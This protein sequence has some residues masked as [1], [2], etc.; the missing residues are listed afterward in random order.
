M[1]KVFKLSVPIDQK[2]VVKILKILDREDDG[3]SF[4]QIAKKVG[5]N[6]NKAGC[7]DEWNKLRGHLLYMQ[8]EELI[9]ERHFKDKT[10][11]YCLEN[12]GIKFVR[13]LEGYSL[14]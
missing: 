3:A 12:A 1:K 11:D 14:P 13:N 2:L 8:G 6:L 10:V 4:L 9:E 7:V 5:F